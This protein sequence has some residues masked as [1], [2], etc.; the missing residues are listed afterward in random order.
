MSSTDICFAATRLVKS[1]LKCRTPSPDGG[2]QAAA[3]GCAQVQVS[4]VSAYARATQSPVLTPRAVLLLLLL[5]DTGETVIVPDNTV[6]RGC[7]QPT[8]RFRKA[9]REYYAPG[10][11]L[12]FKLKFTYTYLHRSVMNW[13]RAENVEPEMEVRPESNAATRVSGTDCTGK[14]IDFAI[15]TSPYVLGCA[16]GMSGTKI[17]YAASRSKVFLSVSP[18]QSPS[19][20][21]QIQETNFSVQSVP[22]MRFL[23]FDFEVDENLTSL[24]ARILTPLP[25][26]TLRAVPKGR[27]EVHVFLAGVLCRAVRLREDLQLRPE[28]GGHGTICCY[29]LCGTNIPYASMRYAVLICHILLRAARYC[30]SGDDVRRHPLQAQPRPAQEEAMSTRPAQDEA[31]NT[32]PAQDEAMNTRPAQEEA[33]SPRPVQDEAMSPRPA[34]DEAMSPQEAMSPRG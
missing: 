16:Y 4:A 5:P 20:R 31:M 33:M 28:K 34:Q 8:P 21:N 14:V 13:M 6:M 19:V 11:T 15:C 25:V 17:G 12:T 7:L 30:V 18:G 24:P 26:C 29:A 27:A 2:V 10:Q 23:V 22:E 32:R 9:F 3:C 1:W